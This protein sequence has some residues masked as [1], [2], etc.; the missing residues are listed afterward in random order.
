MAFGYIHIFYNFA[1]TQGPQPLD[2]MASYSCSEAEI[3]LGTSWG[4]FQPNFTCDSTSNGA[5]V[6]PTVDAII[7]HVK[8]KQLLSSYLPHSAWRRGQ[9]HMV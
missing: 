5:E 3:R 6:L 7:A 2:V 8:W 9:E 4:P 1:L